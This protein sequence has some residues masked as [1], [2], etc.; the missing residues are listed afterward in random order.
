[1]DEAQTNSTAAGDQNQLQDSENAAV[2]G[3]ESNAT[4]S[5]SAP[6]STADPTDN[7][8]KSIKCNE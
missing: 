1:M 6:S 7:N 4:G 8:P 5:S 3:S 2:A